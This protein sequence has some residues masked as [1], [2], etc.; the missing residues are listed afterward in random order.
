[1]QEVLQGLRTLY[2]FFYLPWGLSPL[3]FIFFFLFLDAQDGSISLANINSQ[4]KQNVSGT[5]GCKWKINWRATCRLVLHNVLSMNTQTETCHFLLPPKSPCTHGTRGWA[6]GTGAFLSSAW[7]LIPLL[8]SCCSRLTGAQQGWSESQDRAAAL[9]SLQAWPKHGPRRA[10][11]KVLS[12]SSFQGHQSLGTGQAASKLKVPVNPLHSGVVI[13]H[14]WSLFRAGAF[15]A[16]C[17]SLAM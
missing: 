17:Q 8:G 5:G 11:D 4:C 15:G 1:M 16:S 2:L 6:A 9:P 14:Y 12:F 10:L 3:F 7:E 13:K